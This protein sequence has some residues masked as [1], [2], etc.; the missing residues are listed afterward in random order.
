MAEV[1]A[2]D[3]L[4]R[5][6]PFTTTVTAPVVI[7]TLLTLL[8]PIVEKYSVPLVSPHTPTGNALSGNVTT[9]LKILVF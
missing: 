8:F 4:A 6:S 7:F 1:A 9:L 3:A 5:P 2:V